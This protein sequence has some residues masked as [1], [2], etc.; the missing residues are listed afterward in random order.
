MKL[1]LQSKLIVDYLAA[2]SVIDYDNEAVMELAENIN[3]EK[4]DETDLVKAVFEYVRDNISHSG[5]IHGTHVTCR[6]SDVL[7]HREGLCY[8]K[9]HLLAALLRYHGIPAGFCYQRLTVDKDSAPYI[10]L[11]GL[12][13]VYIASKKKWIRLDA[14]GNRE[15]VDAQFSLDNEKLAFTAHPEAGEE[16]IPVVYAEPDKNVVSRLNAYHN[17]DDLMKNLP[18]GLVLR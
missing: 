2:S 1:E 4:L 7:R 13:G 6:A 9:S 17:V 16:D 15:D 18:A 14:R 3:K 12:N 8:A 5:D 11:H 10:A